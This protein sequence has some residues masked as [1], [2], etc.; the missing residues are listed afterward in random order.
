MD[1]PAPALPA[2]KAKAFRKAFP[3]TKKLKGAAGAGTM[4]MGPGVSH[5]ER[6]SM[7]VLPPASSSP[8]V[9]AQG[10]SSGC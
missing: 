4:F 3:D 2:W 9:K 6:L 7:P 1:D 8:K 5:T 10:E